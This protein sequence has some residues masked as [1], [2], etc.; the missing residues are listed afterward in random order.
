MSFRSR[1]LEQVVALLAVALVSAFAVAPAHADPSQ[2]AFESVSAAV[3]TPRAGAHGDLT[4]TL[5]FLQDPTQEF[6]GTLLP[7]GRTRTLEIDLPPGVVGNP[8]DFP[9]CTEAQL[10]ETPTSFFQRSCPQD[11][12]VGV[13]VLDLTREQP[14]IIEPVYN[15]QRPNEEDVVARLGFMALTFPTFIDVRLRSG[16]DYGL[17]ASLRGPSSILALIR[18]ETTLWGVPADPI[19]NPLRMQQIEVLSGCKNACLAEGGARP[20]GLEPMPFLSNPTKC[21]SGDVVRFEATSYA[22]PERLIAATAPFPGIT[23]CEAVTFDP[24]LTVEPTSRRASAPTGIDARLRIPQSES[25][26]TVA[27]SALRSATVTL[28][29][30]L[31]LS[32]NA[33]DGLEACGA[34][35]AGYR[36]EGAPPRCPE[37]AKI[38]TAT[39]VS[40]ALAEPLPGS[41]YQRDPE[42]GNLFRIWLVADDLGVRLTIPGEVRP[43]PQTG[44]LRVVFMDA[45]QLPVEEIEL[46]VEGGPR[47]PLIN[48]SSCGAF[49][50]LYE[51]V[52]W[53]GNPATIGETSMR[54]DEGC[55]TGKFGPK[56]KAGSVNPIAGS[57]T[58]VVLDAERKDGEQNIVGLNVTFPEGLLAKLAGVPLCPEAL[59][60][61]GS[62]PTASRVGS[63]AVAAGVGPLPLWIPQPG[64]A[65]TAVYL[66]GPY[67][68][69]PYSVVVK[70]PAQAGPFDLGTVAVRAAIDVDPTTTQVQVRSDAL[71]QILEGVP[72][73]YRHVQVSVNRSDFALNPTDCR[74]TSVNARFI[75]P[76]GATAKASDRFQVG[77]CRELSFKPKLRL[78]LKGGTRRGAN[79]SLQAVLRMLKQGA[80]VDRAAVTLP[81]S[82]FL[83]QSHIRT[84]CTRVQFAA[85]AC[86]KAAIYGRA[87]ATTPLLERPLRGPVYLR[88][89]DNPLPDLVADLR[90]DVDI[91]LA[92]RIDAVDGRM[93]TIFTRVPDAPVRKFVLQM[94]GGE[95][96][97]L[98]NSRNL[99]RRGYSAD[100]SFEGQNGKV[101]QFQSRVSAS[102][103]NGGVQKRGGER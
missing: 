47:A 36:S 30:G 69:A 31:T 10:V 103:P 20:S 13:T 34:A 2:H 21:G 55:D 3:S 23:A 101:K 63:V 59:T 52:P 45:P 100:V 75:S 71:P 91:V 64:K 102:C 58:D 49:E 27:T 50:T 95:R 96:G 53:S 37:A 24:T 82:T 43:D 99:C 8:N 38:G 6:G 15:M 74:A 41:I 1:I 70:V 65:P 35:Q 7:Y 92:G 48:P 29:P 60:T 81:R 61:S 4:L 73:P 87:T 67:K 40:P 83:D 89:S 44:Q 76:L 78:E 9:Q 26:D 16:G 51:L 72:I 62:C 80:N 88:S 54:I 17:T 39:F 57:N 46:H 79:P 42:P 22:E 56:L 93:R 90:G 12:Q 33:G 84:I 77:G 18:A 25:P 98:Q 14:G 11:S 86:P 68:G 5:K 66:A 19:H 97:L 85:R 94:Q 32:P 28:P